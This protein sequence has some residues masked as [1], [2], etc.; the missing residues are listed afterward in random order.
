MGDSLES[1]RLTRLMERTPRR[2]EIVIGLI[3]GPV[4]VGHSD[5]TLHLAL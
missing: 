2:P 1:A 5:L 3:H 4:A